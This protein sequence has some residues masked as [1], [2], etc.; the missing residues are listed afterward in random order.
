MEAYVSPTVLVIG[1]SGT[2]GSKLVD[3]LVPDHQAGLLR[4]VA[5]TRQQEVAHS[6][7]ERGIEVRQLDLDDAEMGGPGAVQPV[8]EGIDRVFL[9]TGYTVRMLAQSKA[10]VDAAVAAD[11]SHLV[12]LGV[13]SAANSTIE[14]ATWHQLVE[15]YIE[16]S[17]MGFTHV[18]P[19]AFMQHLPLSVATPD[20][21]TYFIGDGRTNWV[22]VGDVAAV[23]ATV[24]RDPKPHHGRS[25]HLAAEAAPVTEIAQLLGEITGQPWRYEPAEPAVFYEQLVGA[26]YDPIYMRGVRNYLHRVA[27]GSLVDPTGGYDDIETVSGRKATSLRQ[28]LERERD[29]FL[30]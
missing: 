27:D 11:V 28:F 7:Q 6:L 8:F 23:A 26:G 17:G 13:N 3:E 20:V 18:R 15:A 29:A 2:I 9:L 14:Y 16:R 5:A 10:A 25:Y 21:L 30:R 1:A 24:L 19:S 4:L 12:H 22:D